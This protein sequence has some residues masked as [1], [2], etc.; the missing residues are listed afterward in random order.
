[1]DTACDG[2]FCRTGRYPYLT[3]KVC[4]LDA[5]DADEQGQPFTFR[6]GGEEYVLPPRVDL[7][8]VWAFERNR[9]DAG[10]RILLG[11]DQ[12]G[13]LMASGAGFDAAKVKALLGAYNRH[14]ERYG[15]A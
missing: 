9:L 14:N 7:R 2:F 11:P 1:M 15:T 8:A 4:D 3:P 10:L 13:R 12:Y 6:F 5:L